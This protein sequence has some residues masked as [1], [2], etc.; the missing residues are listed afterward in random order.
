MSDDSTKEKLN[1][2]SM[3]MSARK[4]L[5]NKFVDAGGQVNTKPNTTAPKATKAPP[6]RSP[7][8]SD[9]RSASSRK[10]EPP[11]EASQKTSTVKPIKP[12]QKTDNSVF[13]GKGGLGEDIAPMGT[14]FMFWLDA[15]KSGTVGIAGNRVSTGFYNFITRNVISLMLENQ[16]TLMSALYPHDIM[17]EGNKLTHEDIVKTFT[18]DEDLEILQRYLEMYNEE[19]YKEFLAKYKTTG[20][21]AHPA[22]YLGILI[23]MIK[24]IFITKHY[25]NRIKITAENVLIIYAKEEGMSKALLNKKLLLFKK[26][27]DVIY[28]DFYHKLFALI[29]FAS[30]ININELEHLNKL[31]NITEEDYIGYYTAKR[32]EDEKQKQKEIEE[33]KRKMGRDED[34]TQE[35][36]DKIIETGKALIDRIVDYDK[37]KD[38][39]DY[40]DSKDKIYRTMTL[41]DFLDSEY[42]LIFTNRYVKYNIILEDHR[43]IDYATEFNHAIMAISEL[44]AKLNEYYS[45]AHS[46]IEITGDQEMRLNNRSVLI[47]ERTAQLSLISRNLRTQ[48]ETVINKLKKSLDRLMLSK[49]ERD[50]IIGNPDEVLSVSSSESTGGKKRISGLT[51]MKALTE[52]FYYVTALNYLLAHGELSGNGMLID[53]APSSV[54]PSRSQYVDENETNDKGLIELDGVEESEEGDSVVVLDTRNDGN[55]EDDSLVHT[56]KV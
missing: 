4:D 31:L 8:G 7:S 11:K 38:N 51:V 42:S 24:P 19:T 36:F 9:S 18:D 16:T 45:I 43:K 17:G 27:I 10:K 14:R 33:S 40:I 49:E 48:Y 34:D 1:I 50:R 37:L 28:G 35:E 13:S 22:D 29:K 5:F 41:C 12:A 23:K 15:V 30:K 46:I 3:D 25:S 44:S 2:D 47:K 21:A 32:K 55:D 56:S 6:R 39:L 26:S 52:V 53:D 20:G 54:R